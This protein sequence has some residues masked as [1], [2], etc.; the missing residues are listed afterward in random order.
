MYGEGDVRATTGV[1]RK[2][3]EKH[4]IV[5]RCCK[6]LLLLIANSLLVYVLVYVHNVELNVS[7]YTFVVMA[8]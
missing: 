7:L 5:K 8:T 6:L 2:K 3:H 4:S 1:C